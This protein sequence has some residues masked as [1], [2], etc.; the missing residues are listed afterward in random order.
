M[1]DSMLATTFESAF[2]PAPAAS[3]RKQ[4]EKHRFEQPGA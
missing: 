1:P 3:S 4:R 2:G